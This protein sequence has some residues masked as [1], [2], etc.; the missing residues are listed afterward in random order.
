MIQQATAART[1]FLQLIGTRPAKH[2][3]HV[4]K[5]ITVRVTGVVFFDRI[6]GQ[7]GVAPNGVELQPV[8]GIEKVFR[9]WKGGYATEDNS[10]HG[11]RYRSVP[12]RH[13]GAD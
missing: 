9:E 4:R 11:R 7:D 12:R 10:V 5:T 1:K 8:L 6:H 13:L 2:F 3:V